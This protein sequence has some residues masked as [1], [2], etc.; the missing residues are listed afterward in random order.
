MY[1]HSQ[2]YVQPRI[3]RL[4]AI[5]YLRE[6]P[7]RDL[8]PGRHDH[9]RL[10]DGGQWGPQRTG[11]DNYRFHLHPEQG[12]YFGDFNYYAYMQN[13]SPFN[14]YCDDTISTSTTVDFIRSLGSDDGGTGTSHPVPIL[15]THILRPTHATTR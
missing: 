3:A 15:F 5:T 1:E 14:D 10:L 9:H 2:D 12:H 6:L 7:E 8:R 11:K 4:R 13:T